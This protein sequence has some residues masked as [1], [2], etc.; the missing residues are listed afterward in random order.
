[1]MGSVNGSFLNG[2]YSENAK[3]LWL[4]L[5]TRTSPV[6]RSICID[7]PPEYRSL[8]SLILGRSAIPIIYSLQAKQLAV[9]GGDLIEY[10]VTISVNLGIQVHFTGYML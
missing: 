8:P 3:D 2:N 7:K 4:H 1:M 6:H 10:R 9:L 5:P